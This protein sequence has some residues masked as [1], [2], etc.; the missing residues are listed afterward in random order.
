MPHFVVDCSPAVLENVS[1]DSLMR[2]IG[3]TAGSSGLLRS[4]NSIKVRIQ[5]FEHYTEAGA[6]T[7]FIHVMAYVGGLSQYDSG[8]L[9]EKVIAAVKEQ[10]PGVPIVTMVCLG[11]ME[12]GE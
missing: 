4:S 6:G 12:R 3:D 2:V 11:S 1:P 7:D 9:A 10:A 5:P 8:E